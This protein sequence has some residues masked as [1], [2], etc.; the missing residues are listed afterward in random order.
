VV[1]GS[2]VGQTRRP[3][4]RST[5]NS[6]AT[7]ARP[8]GPHRL[9]RPGEA[10]S[11]A[12]AWASV[13]GKPS[14]KHAGL[15]LGARWADEIIVDGDSTRGSKR[16][17]PA[18][19]LLDGF[20]RTL[21][22]AE[23]LDAALARAG[24]RVDLVV[25]LVVADEFVVDRITGRRVCPTCGAVYQREKPA[26]PQGRR[27][28]TRM[29]PALVHRTDIRQRS[30]RSGWPPTMPQTQPWKPTTR[31][32]VWWLRLMGTSEVMPFSGGR[33]RRLSPGWAR[34]VLEELHP[35]DRGAP[36]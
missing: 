36:R 26:A 10:A 13:R 29:E 15:T 22:Q 34:R 17:S 21:A 33:R 9:P 24:K 31:A 6:S 16:Q 35:D 2:Q 4:M 27:S 14:S 32:R 23:A 8:P 7:T 28:A 11:S 19:V 12:S 18:G 25:S 1:H 5:T 20:P 30:S 3:V